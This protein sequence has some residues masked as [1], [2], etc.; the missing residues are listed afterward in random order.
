MLVI[1]FRGEGGGGRG[2]TLPCWLAPPIQNLLASCCGVVITNSWVDGSYRAC[3][4]MPITLDPCPCGRQQ[5]VWPPSRCDAGC[6]H[7]RR[8][9]I[10]AVQQSL[11]RARCLREEH[12]PLTFASFRSGELYGGGA[13]YAFTSR[14]SACS[15][16]LYVE[17]ETGR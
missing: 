8:I 12:G 2:G 11:Q 5:A 9:Y 1:L 13:L 14:D 6:G 16:V 7:L 3:V 17:A 4:S 10:S 15:C